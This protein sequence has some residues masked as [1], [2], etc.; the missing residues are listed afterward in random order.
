MKYII[1]I[2][3]FLLAPSLIGKPDNIQPQQG[4]PDPRQ[5]EQGKPDSRKFPKHWGRP[6]E[7][8]TRD[9]VKLP[10]K[11][12]MGS[13]TLAKWIAD[14][15][16]KDKENP[17]DKKKPDTE[18]PKQPEG[19]KPELPTKPVKPEIPEEIKSA[20]EE[21]KSTD[22]KLKDD[23]KLKIN[24]LGKDAS[25]EDI[26][27][28]AEKFREDNAELIATQKEL[29][30]KIQNWFKDNKPER[31]KRPEPSEEVK[32]KIKAVHDKKKVLDVAKRELQEK[33]KESKGLTKEEKQA[34]IEK[35]KEENAEKHKA[36]KEAQKELQK[37]IRET[38]QEGDRRQ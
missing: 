24:E 27:K 5:F 37:K 32:E 16:K 6:P 38:K 26:K 20:I 23:F 34:L 10:G 11:F 2:I 3:A 36:L 31:P 14:N 29:G 13:S 15:I 33:L 12:G 30:K 21:H 19:E 4:K 8:Q 7:I 22:K 18:K 1:L 35:F 9:M 25:R 28:L 17:I